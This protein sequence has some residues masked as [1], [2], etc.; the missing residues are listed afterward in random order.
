M[1]NKVGLAMFVYRYIEPLSSFLFNLELQ[2]AFDTFFLK[3]ENFQLMP[4]A[5]YLRR[6]SRVNQ[7]IQTASSLNLKIRQQGQYVYILYVQVTSY[8]KWV[9]TSWTDS[10][11]KEN[12]SNKSENKNIYYGSKK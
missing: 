2:K 7:E 3:L 1:N 6:N 10:R 9:T 5:L 11:C 8:I 12:F 4:D